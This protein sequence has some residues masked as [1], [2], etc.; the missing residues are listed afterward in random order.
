VLTNREQLKELEVKLEAIL[1]IV[2]KY[3]QY[4]GIEILSARIRTFCKCA[5]YPSCSFHFDLTSLLSRA[6]ELQVDAVKYLHNRPA[7]AR[8]AEGKEDADKIAKAFRTMGI[9]CDVF[10]VGLKT[11]DVGLYIDHSQRWTLS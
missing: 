6:I 5:R 8:I 2:A 11:M 4:R 7:G 3:E 1:S 10:Q 9:L